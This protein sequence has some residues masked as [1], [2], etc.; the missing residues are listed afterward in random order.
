MNLDCLSFKV[1]RLLKRAIDI[2]LSVLGLVL[3]FPF[4]LVIALAIKLDSPGNVIYSHRRI[5]KD[6]RP[7]N[8][9]KF[10]SMISGGND[11]SYMQYLH[12]L[13]E[14]ERRDQG[15]ALPY[16]KMESDPRVTRVGKII[17]CFYLDELPQLL[18][19]LLGDMSLVGP[20]PHVQFEVDNYSSEQYR[21]LSVRPGLTGL[22]QT[23]AKAECTFNELILMD[24]DYIDHWSLFLDIYII[25]K[26]IILVT[27]GGEKFWSYMAKNIKNRK[28]VDVSESETTV[29]TKPD[30][31]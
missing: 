7:F 30:L 19:I 17:R 22:W 6:G 24:L 25:L 1:Q 29:I 9:Y 15:S 26:T 18:N 31:W 20:R 14:S 8:L 4:M 5:G 21:R 28:S 11:S 13:I 10:R 27:L 2:I 12:K 23:E 3:L 16:R